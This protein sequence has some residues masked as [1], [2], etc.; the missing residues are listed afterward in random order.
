MDILLADV[1]RYLTGC[2]APPIGRH[3]NNGIMLSCSLKPLKKRRPPAQ[4][5]YGLRA[6]AA[7]GVLSRISGILFGRPGGQIAPETHADYDA[8]FQQVV[9]DE[10]ELCD[11]AYHQ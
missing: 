3:S 11:P 8:M 1:S 7:L 9:K 4:V 5:K 6:M 2:A 10:N